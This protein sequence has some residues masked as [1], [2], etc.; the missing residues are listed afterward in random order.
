MDASDVEAVPLHKLWEACPSVRNRFR[1][2]IPWLQFPIPPKGAEGDGKDGNDNG[3]D[4]KD[5]GIGD[6]EGPRKRSA[7]P[8]APTT[9][10]LEL[11]WEV[12]DRMLDNYHGEF[13]DV[14][15]L[16]KEAWFG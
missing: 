11:N 7:D 13:I 12:L 10:A 9:R 8:H 1:K 4:S 15:F 16:Q 5:P 2:G 3:R 6:E 14:Y